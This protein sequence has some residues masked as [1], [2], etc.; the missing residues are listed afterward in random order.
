MRGVVCVGVVLA[1]AV[2]LTCG[3]AHGQRVLLYDNYES[4][5]LGSVPGVPPGHEYSWW[6]SEHP[7]TIKV[8]TPGYSGT[9]C[10]QFQVS[11]SVGTGLIY[12][13]HEQVP[14]AKMEYYVLNHTF[15]GG[16]ELR[17][18]GVR[19]DSTWGDDYAVQF[20][21]NKRI[22]LYSGAEGFVE[23]S[24]WEY[25]LDTWYYVCREVNCETGEGSFYIEELGTPDCR[26]WSVTRGPAPNLACLDRAV[27]ATSV[28]KAAHFCVDKVRVRVPCPR[29]RMHGQ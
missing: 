28:V 29:R 12:G 14:K 11:T 2:A 18:E 13:F 25:K 15:G 23:Q 5:E 17:L 20:R 6:V 8:V 22:G 21:D 7:E 4:Y 3:V 24:P 26:S 27:L 19:T 1:L 16:S 9:K 10:V